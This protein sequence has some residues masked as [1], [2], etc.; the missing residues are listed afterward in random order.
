MART[1][2]KLTDGND[3]WVAPGSGEYDVY[4]GG[5]NDDIETNGDGSD[6]VY[7]EDGDDQI[8]L[9]GGGSA[10]GGT[11]NDYISAQ[12]DRVLL[13][14]ED[15]DDAI[16]SYGSSAH[17]S[18]G[19]GDEEIFAG[20]GNDCRYGGNGNDRLGD[21]VDG[22][23]RVMIGTSWD[24]VH[25]AS[26]AEGTSVTVDGVEGSMLLESVDAARITIADVFF[27]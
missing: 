26:V 3:Y 10:A 8:H 5:G 21:F 4:A 20:G 11:G 13:F 16:S 2:I 6:H 17:I 19:A 23:V 22:E 12:G 24:H 15:G 7:D 25:V 14:G 9:L 1:T 18:G 27:V